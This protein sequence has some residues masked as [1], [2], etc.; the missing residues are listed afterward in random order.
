PDIALTQVVLED[1]AAHLRASF[2]AAHTSSTSHG[3]APPDVYTLS[4]H[5]ALPIY[6]PCA[7]VE[8]LHLLLVQHETNI[9]SPPRQQTIRR[10][11]GD[12]K[13]TRLNS[14][15]VAISYAV[16]CLKKKKLT[17]RRGDKAFLSPIT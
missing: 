17:L 1:P 16:F 11:S 12:R 7:D 15:H 14:S 4:L 2:S 8:P 9:P 6:P 13:S 3:P 5:D 10:C